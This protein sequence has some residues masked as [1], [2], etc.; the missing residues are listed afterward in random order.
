[1]ATVILKWNPNF[2]SYSMFHYLHDIV[3]LNY[4]DPDYF[5]WSVWDYDKVHVWGT[6]RKV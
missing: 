5:N 3:I 2:S 4:N 6:E 1:M